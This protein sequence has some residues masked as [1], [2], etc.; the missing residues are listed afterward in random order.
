MSYGHWAGVGIEAGGEDYHVV[1]EDDEALEHVGEPGVVHSGTVGDIPKTAMRDP[2]Y[3][4]Q[5]FW[6]NDGTLLDQSLNHV[7]H[8]ALVDN[9]S[10]KWAF[11]NERYYIPPQTMGWVLCLPWGT[12]QAKVAWQAPPGTTQ[13]TSITNAQL[14]IT[15]TDEPLNPVTG[16]PIDPALGPTGALNTSQV[17]VTTGT[18]IIAANGARRTVTIFNTA[19]SGGN[20]VYIGST[21]AVT[22]GTGGA[23]PPQTG[24]TLSNYSGALFGSATGGSSTTVT[25]T[26]ESA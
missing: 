22:T 10:G 8:Y 15:Y 20:V 5:V 19:A 16:I 4:H 14:G 18:S 3:L 23:I 21:S 25:V 13:L 12:S 26:E 7:A 2:V 9:W 1:H 24:F 17:A 11:I 6:V